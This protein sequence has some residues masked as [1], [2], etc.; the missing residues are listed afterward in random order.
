[1]NFACPYCAE[2]VDPLDNQ[3][4]QKVEGWERPSH[5]RASGKHGG[6]DIY[7]RR[8]LDEYAHRFCVERERAGVNA[9]QETL[10]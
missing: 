7:H 6:S 1:M 8:K 9:R 5:I 4:L 3:T 2:P 10:V